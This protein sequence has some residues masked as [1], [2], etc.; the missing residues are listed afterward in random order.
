MISFAFKALMGKK[1]K[2]AEENPGELTVGAR[3]DRC[4]SSLVMSESRVLSMQGER[5]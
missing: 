5:P 4:G 2:P 1:K 3:V